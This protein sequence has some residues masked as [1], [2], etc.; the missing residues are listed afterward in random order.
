MRGFWKP[1]LDRQT[2]ALIIL[3]N[4]NILETWLIAIV[5]RV[6]GKKILFWTHGWLRHE[7][8]VKSLVRRLYY[9]L[10]NTVLVYNE[11]ARAL[12]TEAGFPPERIE[13]IYTS[14]DWSK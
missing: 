2:D 5:G 1:V 7:H 12:G 14:L 6:L 3:G 13:V 8:F 4:P 9:R 10:A 11:R